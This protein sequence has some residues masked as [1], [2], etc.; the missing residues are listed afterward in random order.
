MPRGVAARY[1]DVTPLGVLAEEDKLW[2]VESVAVVVVVAVLNVSV[3]DPVSVN[4][5]PS[6]D[7]HR[8]SD[9][10]VPQ[11]FVVD[12]AVGSLVGSAEDFLRV[13]LMN[14]VRRLWRIV[15]APGVFLGDASE[16]VH[17]GSVVVPVV[18]VDRWT[19]VVAEDVVE[20]QTAT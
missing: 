17:D 7:D 4:R 20:V 5:V 11:A 19:S 16:N 13:V 3:L 14:G 1:L 10:L 8:H 9:A 6:V 15:V 18:L 2:P 12:T